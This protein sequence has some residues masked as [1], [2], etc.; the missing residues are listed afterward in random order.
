MSRHWESKVFEGDGAEAHLRGPAEWTEERDRYP[1]IPP[2]RPLSLS[3]SEIGMSVS[4]VLLLGLTFAFAPSIA[5]HLPAPRST[6]PAIIE[7]PEELLGSRAPPTAIG[8]DRE[9]APGGTPGAPRVVALRSS[10]PTVKP[11]SGSD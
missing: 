11:D 7:T 3:W 4:A 5:I 10:T 1:D 2:A 6:R 9:K 8:N